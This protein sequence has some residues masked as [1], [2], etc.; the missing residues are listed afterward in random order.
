MNATALRDALIGDEALRTRPYKDTVGKLTIGVGRNLDDR[1]IT[2]DE[3]LYLLN[4][5]IAD[6]AND[7][8]T[9]FAWFSKLDWVRQ[10]V[11]LN[12]RFQLGPSRFRGFKKLLSAVERGDYADAAVQMA[13]SAWADQVPKRAQRL[14]EAM[15]QGAALS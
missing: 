5:D 1:G 6:C 8:A 15:Q 12:M 10:N 14:I 7:L 2:K 3:A 9:S 11:L 4:N 13:D